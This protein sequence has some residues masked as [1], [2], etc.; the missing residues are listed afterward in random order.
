VVKLDNSLK[1][2]PS[3]LEKSVKKYSF[4]MD[5]MYLKYFVLF[6]LTYSWNNILTLKTK[7]NYFLWIHF[8]I[9]TCNCFW[10]RAM[11][12]LLYLGCTLNPIFSLTITLFFHIYT[13]IYSKPYIY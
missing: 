12:Y 9:V 2:I 5:E 13:Q 8:F 3:T 1:Y 4:D 7:S 11:S 10:Y 6:S